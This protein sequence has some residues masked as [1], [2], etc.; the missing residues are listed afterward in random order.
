MEHL[1]RLRGPSARINI[2]LTVFA[3]E[4]IMDDF[5]SSFAT[6]F[7]IPATGVLV[8]TL[9]IEGD[10]DVFRVELSE[11]QSI[12]VEL[13]GRTDGVTANDAMLQGRV[14]IQ[15][16]EANRFGEQVPSDFLDFEQS[17]EDADLNALNFTAPEA[18][19]Y[20][21]TVAGMDDSPDDGLQQGIGKYF[22]TVDLNASL[23]DDHADAAA[24]ATPIAANSAVTGDIGFESDFFNWDDE[25]VF[26]IELDAGERVQIDGRGRSLSSSFGILDNLGLSLSFGDLET[27]V[28]SDESFDASGLFS[29]AVPAQ[30]D[31]TAPVS[32]TYFITI[33]GIEDFIPAEFNSIGTYELTVDVS[34]TA[35]DV[36]RPSYF[37]GSIDTAGEIDFYEVTVTNGNVLY[38]NARGV[39][40]ADPLESVSVA[41]TTQDGQVIRSE[42]AENGEQAAFF[43]F[44]SGTF[45]VQVTGADPLEISG[46]QT[47]SYQA[48]FGYGQGFL[49]D[50]ALN[51]IEVEVDALGGMLTVSGFIT[52]SG[53]TGS[54]EADLRLY[55]TDRDS[56][57]R[58][59]PILFESTGIVFPDPYAGWESETFRIPDNLESGTYRIA[60]VIDPDRR[61][62]ESNE[63]NNEILSAEFTYTRPVFTLEDADGVTRMQ[64]SAV[65]EIFELSD[66]GA[67]DMLRDFNP[68]RDKIDVSAL[69]ATSLADLTIVD[70]RRK[71]GSVSWIDIRD[72]SGDS[73]AILRVE[74]GFPQFS[75][76]LNED[77][78]IFADAPPP[79][80]DGIVIIGTARL[81]N[82]NGTGAADTFVLQDDGLRDLIRDFDPGEDVISVEAFGATSFADIQL[83]D[84]VRRDGSISWV[85]LSDAAGDAEAILRFAPGTEQLSAAA[86]TAENFVFVDAP[87][88]PPPATVVRDT[89]GVDR[90]TG[91]DANELFTFRKDGLRDVLKAFDPS[92]DRLDLTAFDATSFD[93]LEIVDLVRRDWSVSW[94][95]IRDADQSAELLVRFRDAADTDASSLTAEMFDL[96]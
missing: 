6:A 50:L 56:F 93:D 89:G 3:S 38:V 96:A 11:G 58:L 88:P 54:T 71:D 77:D 90:L 79:P 24:L 51:E 30:I 72:P 7:S 23:V 1:L 9:E 78:F 47:G 40:G 34:D 81:D 41:I 18:G 8:G 87:P 60:A 36:V 59:D 86:L 85:Q 46:D 91:T 12:E 82:L 76:I 64:G 65:D 31:Y 83:T 16:L 80:V 92:Q 68:D 28:A 22:L 2:V 4:R 53:E 17:S 69:G 94:V 42:T 84:L 74:A 26:S 63:S 32:G 43:F 62:F 15:T 27:V 44:L 49:P 10:L 29:D 45:M 57:S 19:T 67:R 25:D 13:A 21:I 61:V 66:D 73:E 95:E 52:N 37:E 48:S 33:D 35:T 14:F 20:Y 70:L 5:G 55:L 75:A 39:E